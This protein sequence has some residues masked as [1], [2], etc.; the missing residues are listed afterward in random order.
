MPHPIGLSWARRRAFVG[1]SLAATWSLLLLLPLVVDARAA[2]I[3]Y[4]ASAPA[5]VEPRDV[6]LTTDDLPPGFTIDPRYTRDGNLDPVGPAAQVQYIRNAT[7]QNLADGPLVVGQLVVRLD[8]PLGAGDALIAVRQRL[9]DA[10][11]F[12]PSDLGPNDGGTFT[13]QRMEG[14]V[15]VLTLGFIKENMI[16]VTSVGGVPGS[17]TLDAVLQLAGISS[18]RLDAALGR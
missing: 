16:I 14:N 8:G 13:L 4:A 18:A 7:P 17:V 11:G 1:A 2:P 10:Q 6:T 15:Q 9:I 5:Q 12:V 3:A